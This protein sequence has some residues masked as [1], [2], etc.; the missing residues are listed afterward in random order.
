MC[1][2]TAIDIPVIETVKRLLEVDFLKSCVV[3]LKSVCYGQV[4]S[5]PQENY[6]L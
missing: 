2:A 5:V 4:F 1:A 6:I 3:I